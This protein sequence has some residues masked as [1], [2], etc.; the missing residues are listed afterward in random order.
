MVI[1]HHTLSGGAK[2]EKTSD[3]KKKEGSTKKKIE[4]KKKKSKIDGGVR[5]Q[6]F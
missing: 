5:A 6:I 4:K 1:K 3:L 2:G